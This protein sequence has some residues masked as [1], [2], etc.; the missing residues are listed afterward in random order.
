MGLGNID[1]KHL[2]VLLDQ[3]V[4]LRLVKIVVE[5]NGTESGRVVDRMKRELERTVAARKLVVDTHGQTES[6]WGLESTSYYDLDLDELHKTP[7]T[8]SN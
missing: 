6:I 1:W 3:L 8:T 4:D 7:F 5:L 2:D